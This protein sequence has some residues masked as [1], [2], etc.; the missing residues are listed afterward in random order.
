MLSANG[1]KPFYTESMHITVVLHTRHTSRHG[2]FRLQKKDQT[3]SEE[4]TEYR[5]QKHN[6]NTNTQSVSCFIVHAV[7]SQN[8][9]MLGVL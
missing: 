6:R 8:L 1:K 7:P 5:E 3:G 2:S 9:D 4:H